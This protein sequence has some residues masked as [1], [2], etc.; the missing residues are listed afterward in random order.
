MSERAAVTILRLPSVIS[1]T[2][3]SR[4]SIYAMMKQS[5]FPQTLSLGGERAVGWR[6]IDID[7]WLERLTVKVRDTA[8]ELN[9]PLLGELPES[10]KKGIPRTPTRKPKG[11]AVTPTTAVDKRDTA[12]CAGGSDDG[13][14][15]TPQTPTVPCGD[16]ERPDVGATRSSLFPRRAGVQVLP[17]PSYPPRVQR[18]TS[19]G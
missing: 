5:R 16:V 3:L 18:P 9:A 13:A 7:D 12:G 8:E 6:S 4:S 10:K 14:R 19:V 1:R 11:A 2:G 17:R 15:V